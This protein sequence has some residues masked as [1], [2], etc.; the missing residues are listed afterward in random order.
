MTSL[1]E[2]EMS[3]RASNT[4]MASAQ[5]E[6]ETHR[7]ERSMMRMGACPF[8]V[9]VRFGSNLMTEKKYG[10]GKCTVGPKKTD[11]RR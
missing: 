6:S 9:K 8:L 11:A 3:A 10:T 1:V 4:G 7:I 2:V 5:A